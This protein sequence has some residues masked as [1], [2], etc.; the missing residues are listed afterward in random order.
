MSHTHVQN[1]MYVF[2][3]ALLPTEQITSEF[4][5]LDLTNLTWTIVPATTRPPSNL[6]GSGTENNA[7]IMKIAY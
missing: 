1:T 7:G 3:G 6:S 2:G 5:A 4:W